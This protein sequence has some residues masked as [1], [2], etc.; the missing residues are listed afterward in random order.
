MSQT[1]LSFKNPEIKI[2]SDKKYSKTAIKMK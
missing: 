1:L 2:V